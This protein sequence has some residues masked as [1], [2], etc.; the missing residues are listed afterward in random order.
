M[1][2]NS[3]IPTHLQEEL[4]Q[5]GEDITQH[6]F[7]IGDII[8]AV[9]DF[10]EAN[11]IPCSK[12]DV[13][14]AVGSYIGKAAATVQGYEALARFYPKSVR[15]H[16]PEL[17]AS[18]FDKARKIESATDHNWQTVLDYAVSKIA[19]YGRPA[20]VDELTKVFIY[21]GE[22]YDPESQDIIPRSSNPVDEFINGISQLRRVIDLLP[23]PEHVRRSMSDAIKILEETLVTCDI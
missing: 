4:I 11:H 17:S 14:R 19:D 5:I 21:D 6:T 13:W 2:Y 23:V 8:I 3:I 1:S 18:H 12:R 22:E 10:V 9:I 7:R 20:T 15:K 16:Y